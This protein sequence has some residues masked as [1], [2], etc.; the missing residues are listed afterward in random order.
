[1][2]STHLQNTN[3]GVAKIAAQV[4]YES[5]SAFNRAFKLHVGMPPG[6]W[7]SRKSAW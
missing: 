6:I 1:M 7:R 2:A 4:G 5:E 3:A